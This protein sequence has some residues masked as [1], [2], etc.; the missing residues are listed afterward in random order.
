MKGAAAVNAA[1]SFIF[2]AKCEIFRNITVTKKSQIRKKRGGVEQNERE[3]CHF[4][5]KNILNLCIIS[6]E[7]SAIVIFPID[8]RRNMRYTKNGKL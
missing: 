7:C 8:K 3:M 1:A 2:C 5:Q 6:L 4:V